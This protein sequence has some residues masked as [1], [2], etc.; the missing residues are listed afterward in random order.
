MSKFQK[1]TS[2]PS[3]R[4]TYA[5]LTP[6]LAPRRHRPALSTQIQN[7]LTNL[8]SAREH[9][10]YLE[11]QLVQACQSSLNASVPTN[12]D[13]GLDAELAEHGNE[14]EPEYYEQPM[15]FGGQKLSLS[16][17]ESLDLVCLNSYIYILQACSTNCEQKERENEMPGWSSP[18]PRG[19]LSSYEKSCIFN[20][21]LYA[22]FL[23]KGSSFLDQFDS[24]DYRR[25]NWVKDSEGGRDSDAEDDSV[26][27]GDSVTENNLVVVD[28]SLTEDDSVTEVDSVP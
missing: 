19:K 1:I 2:S 21:R 15:A 3:V 28:G 20:P 11:D 24:D 4:S 5:S 8:T 27:E 12:S 22:A 10:Q 7:I 17:V 23:K 18:P 25:Y 13:S 26:A 14:Q 6:R 9:V 16:D